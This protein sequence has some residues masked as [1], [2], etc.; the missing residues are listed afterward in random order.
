MMQLRLSLQVR[1]EE[2]FE[3]EGASARHHEM[4]TGGGF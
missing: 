3:G 1:I 4:H 2:A